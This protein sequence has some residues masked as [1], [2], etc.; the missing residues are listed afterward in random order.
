MSYH[1]IVD[2]EGNELEVVW[3]GGLLLPEYEMRPSLIWGGTVNRR[4][5]NRKPTVTANDSV[6]DK[7][8]ENARNDDK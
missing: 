7:G 4:R 8:D 2:D 5:Y 1:M 3:N 6:D